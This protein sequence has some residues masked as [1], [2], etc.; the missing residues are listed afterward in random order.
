MRRCLRM[1]LLEPED[2]LVERAKIDKEAFGVLY[3][4]YVRMV[5]RYMYFKTRNSEEAEDL[6]EKTFFQALNALGRYQSR[7]M[8]FG[9]WIF[10][11]A[12]NIVVNWYRDTRKRKIFNLD[13]SLTEG[14]S[15]KE[16][17]IKLVERKE[18]A[19]E[20]RK[21]IAKLPA[22]RQQLLFLKFVEELPNARIAVLMRKSEGAIK[23][24]LH[25]TMRSIRVELLS[26]KGLKDN[27]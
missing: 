17:P 27:L 4:R 25:R 7:G 10:R 19:E 9:A 20:L 1:S 14:A 16:E 24:L 26:S 8:P 22:D 6:T 13:H 12:H 21:L 18:E 2:E 23:A 3:N 11:I 15:S 5:Y